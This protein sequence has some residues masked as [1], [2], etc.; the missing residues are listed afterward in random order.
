M[1][2]KHFTVLDNQFFNYAV[3][4]RLNETRYEEAKEWCDANLLRPYGVRQWGQGFGRFVFKVEDDATLFY[5][6]FV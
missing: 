3:D 6:M 1:I 2:R 5:L 4:V